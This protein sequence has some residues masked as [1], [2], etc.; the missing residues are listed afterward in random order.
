MAKQMDARP[1]TP[2][3]LVLAL[4]PF[5]PLPPPNFV[6]SSS[7]RFNVAAAGSGQ[8]PVAPVGGLASG[9][10]LLHAATGVNAPVPG[11]GPQPLPPGYPYPAAP[12]YHYPVPP[13]YPAPVPGFPPGFPISSEQDPNRSSQVFKLPPQTTA[14]DPIR[15]RGEAGFPWSTLL[16]GIGAFLVLGILGYGIYQAL[17][18]PSEIP[19]DTFINSQEIRMVK[20]EGGK[21][22][23][24]SPDSETG[25]RPEESPVHEV[26]VKGPFL[27]SATEVSHAQFLKVMG[28]SP[29]KSAEKA[30]KAQN[31]PVEYVTWDEANDF[32]RKL[33]ESEKDQKWMRK[34]WA[35]RLPTEAE[36]EY[37]AR[38]GTETP[39]AFGDRIIYE[40]QALFKP[41]END[42]IG[43]GGVSKPPDF[44]QE[45][46][47]TEPNGFGLHD[48]HGNVA[49]WCLDW[50]KSGYPV[51]GPHDNPTGPLSGDKRVVRGGS[52]KDPA[53]GVRSAARIGVRPNE[54]NDNVGFRIVY[55]PQR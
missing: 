55:A 17:L 48:M 45:V 40:K 38:A 29:T 20:L 39:F 3:E 30:A 32:C 16:L 11:S 25:H 42:V 36:W 26:T 43:M 41:L 8:H 10:Q 9:Q 49:E 52:F 21:F 1:R 54:R 14:D 23:M 5:C 7:G 33:T 19:L 22:R 47:K 13:G 44:P 53:I 31:R 15:R 4:Q 50:Y 24:G 28:T 51:D 2:L 34:G 37:A 12:G 46:G 27:I 6:G 18:S 35:Y